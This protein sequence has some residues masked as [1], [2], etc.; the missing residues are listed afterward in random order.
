[1]NKQRRVTEVDILYALDRMAP[2]RKAPDVWPAVSMPAPYPKPENDLGRRHRA[3]IRDVKTN[4]VLL[5]AP[6]A[7]E[8]L[9]KINGGWTYEPN[10]KEGLFER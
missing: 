7:Y 4:K 3:F 8:L 5:T 1:M 10:K 9:D 6:S 2:F